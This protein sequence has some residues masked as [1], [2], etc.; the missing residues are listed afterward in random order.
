VTVSRLLAI[1]VIFVGAAVAWFA[2]GA[3]LTIRSGEH[4]GRL[5]HDVARLWG[6]PQVQVAPTATIQRP[7]QV[8]ETVA[9]KDADGR[10]VSQREVTRQ[11]FSEVPAPLVATEADVRLDLEHRQRGLL[12]YDT[13]AVAFRA[14]YTFRNPDPVERSVR[15]HFTFP[16][17]TSPYDDFRFLVD[18]RPVVAETDLES[19]VS[20]DAVV[21][22]GGSVRLEVGYRSRGL[23]TWVYAFDKEGVSQVHDFTLAMTTDF[24][25]VDFPV[26]T[27]SPSAKERTAEGWTLRWAF[28]NLV[29]GQRLGMDLPNR[30]NPGPLA[31]RITFFA[32]VSLLFFLTV[33]VMLGVTK[34]ENLHPMNYFFLTG[35]FFAFHLLLAYLVDHVSIHVA[36]AVA[37]FVSLFLVTSYLRV[38]TGMRRALLHAGSAQLVFLVLFSYAFFF[39]GYTGL[40]V[41]VGAVITLFVLMQ[42]TARVQWADVC[43]TR[44]PRAS[45]EVGR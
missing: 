4:D 44:L 3:S 36:F 32:P 28:T 42:M 27:L 15:L 40:A 25:A 39:E 1:V 22:G 20:A 31:A 10:V 7:S 38:V 34:C 33:L 17:E 37:A 45:T 13:Y 43:A 8:T 26:G 9:D 18:G 14:T 21:A 30:L 16:N 11:R 41:T 35:A 12:W 24:E 23:D 29:T 2:L 5:A 6:G 19:G